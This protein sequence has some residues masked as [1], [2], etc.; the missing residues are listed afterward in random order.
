MSIINI[1]L[2]TSEWFD[3]ASIE[4]IISRKVVSAFANKMKNKIEE[5]IDEKFQE[6]INNKLLSLMEE[7]INKYF[8]LDK[9]KTNSFGEK[10]GETTS[11]F[12]IYAEKMDSYLKEKVKLRDGGV[13]SYSDKQ[14][15]TRA[16]FIIKKIGDA[17]LQK[18][19][20]EQVSKISKLAQEQIKASVAGYISEK[21]TPHIEVPS[22]TKD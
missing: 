12:S 22:L 3:E 7:R 15:L 4:E 8:S 11:L 19:I 20:D 17:D 14:T 1:E 9:E 18:A 6:A 13:A 10:T 16:E 21:L 2:D 5:D